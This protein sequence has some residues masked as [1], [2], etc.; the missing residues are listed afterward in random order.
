MKTN[1]SNA[2]HRLL[3]E[4]VSPLHHTSESRVSEFELIAFASSERAKPTA[5]RRA[6]LPVRMLGLLFAI[7]FAT[8]AFAAPKQKVIFDCDLAGDVDDAYAAA[9]L[10]ASPEFEVLGLVMDHG[11]TWGRAR[12]AG[13]LLYE[14]GLEEKIPE[15][16]R[17]AFH[18]VPHS[19]TPPMQDEAFAWLD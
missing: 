6:F 15:R 3:A 5:G 19:F 7:G 1:E 8:T 2:S 16:F 17:G 18:D 4:D 12:V 13:R 14:L 10:L 9:L 11:H